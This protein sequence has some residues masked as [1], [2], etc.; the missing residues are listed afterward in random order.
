MVH[1]IVYRGGDDADLDFSYLS[2]TNHRS[3]CLD[4]VLVIGPL[5]HS[6]YHDWGFYATGHRIFGRFHDLLIVHLPADDSETPAS[7]RK[8]RN[9]RLGRSERIHRDS[10]SGYGRL[11]L[12]ERQRRRQLRLH[13]GWPNGSDDSESD[14][15]LGVPVDLGTCHVVLFRLGWCALVVR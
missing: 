6:R 5:G 11:P 9:V 3:S 12:T 14:C 1:E 13:G 15:Q 7:K 4:L 10:H 2:V 8:A